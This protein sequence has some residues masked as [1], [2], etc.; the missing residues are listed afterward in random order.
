METKNQRQSGKMF[1]YLYGKITVHS[2][3]FRSFDMT[4]LFIGIIFGTTFEHLYEREILYRSNKVIVVHINTM[5][6][7]NELFT[8]EGISALRS[9]SLNRNCYFSAASNSSFN[10]T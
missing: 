7:V 9:D 8:F 4:P 3:T 10:K 6:R 1:N 2:Q 5:K